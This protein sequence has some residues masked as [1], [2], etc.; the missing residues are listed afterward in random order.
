MFSGYLRRST[1]AHFVASLL[2]YCLLDFLAPATHAAIITSAQLFG[3]EYGTGPGLGTVDIPV[4][5]TPDSNNDNQPGGTDNNI[6][7]PI[8]R[9]DHPGYI[10]IVFNVSPSSGTTEYKFFESVDNN[11]FVPWSSY[12][13]QLG[14]GTG[15][16]FN[17]TGGAS[18][19]LDFDDPT[20]D[21][22]P[23]SSAFSNISMSPDLLVFSNGL[24]LSGAETFQFRIDVPDGI[25][26]F[27]LRQ[28][29]TAIP[30]PSLCVLAALASL[31]WL[32]HRRGIRARLM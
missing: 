5:A 29:P 31:G 12:T 2:A 13:M 6:I 3:S 32:A 8:K 1:K 30:E 9:F 24:L 16:A 17:N 22:A 18:D 15:L 27:T 7:V 23:S 4:I 14:F 11:T 26:S 28:T 10:D 25:T 20:Y 19:G 21:L